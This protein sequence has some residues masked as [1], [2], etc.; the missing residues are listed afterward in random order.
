M[1]V[2]RKLLS[3]APEVAM[4]ILVPFKPIF[5][6]LGLLSG[7]IFVGFIGSSLLEGK[8]PF[9]MDRGEARH[10]VVRQDAARATPEHE[11]PHK[12]PSVRVQ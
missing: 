7:L 12:A 4:M 1:E 2:S 10:T 3:Y 9:A 6:V 11:R 5:L 8:E